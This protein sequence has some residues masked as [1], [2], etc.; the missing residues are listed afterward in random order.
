MDLA[1][2][3]RIV[4]EAISLGRTVLVE[5]EAK[6]VL[7]LATIPVPRFRVVKDVN[8]AMDVAEEVGYPLVLK[9]VSP[10]ILHMSDVGGVEVGIGDRKGMEDAWARMILH[11]AD[12][13]PMSVIEGFIIEEMVPR[14]VEVIVGAIKDEQ[15]G[16]TVMFG[17]GGI[18][19]ELMKDVS[20]RLGPL[21]KDSAL[22][23]M[24][25]VKGFPLLTGYRGDT[26]KDIESVA[27]VMV[28][29]SQIVEGTNG[30]KELEINPIMVYEKG[31]L[32]VDARATVGIED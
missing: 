28:K 9:V 30:I 23:M 5:P 10:D 6:E 8:V 16:T 20:F 27:E 4:K 21:D 22:E 11:V 13:K 15:F 2:I 3:E 7:R 17:T 1:A 18:A 14:G 26:V 12:E 32:A 31:V 19:V 25:E 24:S 29:L